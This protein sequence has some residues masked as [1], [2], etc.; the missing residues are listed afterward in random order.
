[1]SEEIP[2]YETRRE[3]LT[4]SSLNRLARDL[5]EDALPLVWIEGELSNVS[6]PASGHLYFTLKDSAAQVRCAMF[7]PRSTWLRFK[8]ADGTHVLARARV[9]LYEARGEFQL[10]VEHMEEA[11]EGAL[12]RAFD[13]L[14]AKLQSEGLFDQQRKRALPRYPRRIGVITSATGAAIRDVLSVA[15]RRCPLTEIEILSVPVQGREAPPAIVAMLNAASRSARHDVLLLTRG[16]GSLEDL[17]AFNDEAVARAVAASAVPVVCAVGHE[18]DFSIADFVADL[19]APTPSAAA[20]LLLPDS[21]ALTRTLAQHRARIGHAWNRRAHARSQRLDHLH[22]RLLGRAP[23]Q[24]LAAG[25]ER[26]LAL[27]ARMQRCSSARLESAHARLRHAGA[28]L[29]L[30]HPARRLPVLARDAQR[31]HQRLLGAWAQAAQRD[32]RRVAAL[33][34]ALQAVSPLNVLQRGYAILF[35][36]NGFVLRSAKAAAP[37]AKLTARLQDGEL[38]LV[39]REHEG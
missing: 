31:F 26:L 10:L 28:R 17:I 36:E 30:A 19:R 5:I 29:Q 7:K 34:R 16:G 8:P 39:V 23:Q 14:K 27:R 24:R 33:A 32:A 12:R 35:D 4:P 25:R 37:G 9:S 6:R 20:E 15:R 21:D 38:A 1:M 3:I 11:G 2:Q 22:A 18:V 13:L